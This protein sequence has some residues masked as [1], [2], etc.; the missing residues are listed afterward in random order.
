ME[1]GERT[2]SQV[3]LRALMAVC[4]LATK[5][6]YLQH[7][8]CPA[9]R[10]SGW[11][12]APGR[13]CRAG[14]AEAGACPE[15]A[16]PPEAGGPPPHRHHLVGPVLLPRPLAARC[17]AL[18][19]GSQ[20]T[21][22]AVWAPGWVGGPGQRSH[23]SVLT[24]VPRRFWWEHRAVFTEAQRR[25]LGQHSLSRVICDN[26]GLTRVPRDA[27]QVAQWP[28]DFESCDR[29]PGMDLRAWREAPPPGT[30]TGTASFSSGVT[31]G[32][33]GQEPRVSE[34]RGG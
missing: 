20:A 12:R 16:G 1:Q 17:A 13:S 30:G 2:G 22:G 9:I 19:G 3:W 18:W 26:T 27:F 6:A 33:W 32:V 29:I 34:G 5:G 8:D 7:W 15:A 11:G 10:P 25:E 23:R 31:D 28:R 24:R 14:P 4:C 21:A